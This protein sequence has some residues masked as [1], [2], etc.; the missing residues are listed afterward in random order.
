[1]NPRSIINSVRVAHIPQPDYPAIAAYLRDLQPKQ[2]RSYAPYLGTVFHLDDDSHS[3]TFQD[4]CLLPLGD[5]QR[6]K[7]LLLI[8]NAHP[9]SIKNG[10]FH[11]AEGGVALLW[12]DLCA[13]GL[14]SADLGT[15]RSPDR[16]RDSCLG[17]KYD[18]PFCLGFACYWS[19]PTFHPRHLRELFRPEVEPPGFRDTDV[20]FARLVA[21]W[22]PTAIVSFNGD[23][24][25]RLTG[26]PTRGY[27][28]R[29]RQGTVE[30]VY[31]AGFVTC[32]VFQTYPAA[33]R[34]DADADRLRRDSL[35]RIAGRL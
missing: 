20:R 34:Y 9:E 2:R 14:F 5:R 27:T 15:V 17:L 28:D 6:P 4:E 35:R 11:T 22:Q 23:V 3:V 31:R 18:G 32:S 33:W 1:M 10:M 19:F 30:A 12:K 24:F 21:D 26:M 8:S 13:A 16:L 29:L 7:L 25:G